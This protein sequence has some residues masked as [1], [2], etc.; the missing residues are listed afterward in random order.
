MIGNGK[1]GL[2]APVYTDL[3]SVQQL[4]G[5][6]QLDRNAALKD[7]ARQFE[8]IMLGMMLK[9]MREAGA[10]FSEGNPLASSEQQFYQD[11]FDSQLSLTLAQKG[12]L[13]IAEALL[14]QLQRP[15]ERTNTPAGIGP[16][17]SLRRPPRS[18]ALR[19]GTLEAARDEELAELVYQLFSGDGSVEVSQEEPA[20]VE[21]SALDGSPAS[22]VA[23][24]LPLARQVGRRLGVD[25]RVLISQAA[26]ETGWGRKVIQKPG[27]GS[28][29]NFFNIKAGPNWQGEVVT[30][31]TIEY[32]DGVAVREWAA[33][34]AY[35]SPEES[36]AD[37]ARLIAE[38][39]R[40]R[41]ALERASDPRAYL[42]ALAGAGYATDPQYASKI[43]ALLGSDHLRHADTGQL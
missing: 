39:P 26:L 7:I 25:S 38:N 18:E 33:F 36:F 15:G 42:Q 31:P 12:G 24:L 16:D 37:Y 30:V 43:M 19:P 21:T 13:G 20:P 29:H 6:A 32:R 9:S 14:R 22:F 4:K 41:S 8:S 27:G 17:T 10:V 1:P 28:S 35:A 40:Y 23:T 34:R 3:N 5:K 2:S 11:M